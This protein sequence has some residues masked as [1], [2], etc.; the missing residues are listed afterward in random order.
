MATTRIAVLG[1]GL[2]GLAAATRLVAAGHQVTVYEARNRVG[3]RV[4]T[5]T[6]NA[7]GG[8]YPIERGAEFVLNGYSTLN[9][10][11]ESHSLP[12]I[13]TGMSYYIRTPADRPDVTTEDMAALGKSAAARAATLH[14]AASVEQVLD[15]IEVTGSVRDAL[16]ARIE[17]STAVRVDQVTAEGTLDQVASFKPGPS[18][19]VAGGNQR[20]PLAMASALGDRV[21]LGKVVESVF[22]TPTEVR[23]TTGGET[24][25]YDF[26]V[27]A[28]PF[29]IVSDPY[30]LSIDLPEWKTD[31][32]TRVV[33]G[34]AA[35]L[36]IPLAETPNTSAVMSV[37]GR[38]W[39]WTA[40]TSESVVAPVVNC[41]G[42]EIDH[43]LQLKIHE[44]GHEWERQVRQLRQDL[45]FEESGAVLTA[46]PFD[47]LAR[48]SYTAHAPGFTAADAQA[49]A[50]PYG[51][52]FFAGEYIDTDF[53]GLMEGALRS[54]D[55]AAAAIITN[56]SVAA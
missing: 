9:A 23:I 31:A 32:M 54:G 29:A 46:W 51:R 55:R 3:G 52:L 19:R 38:H 6:I 18:W 42:G 45:E 25:S 7:A 53:T 15:L 16:A 8:E 14:E 1:A 34:N 24:E 40:N 39:S 48:G 10:Y 21:R 27:V 28:L 5:E 41:F 47:P 17:M 12:L 36:H 49:L 26:V 4:W 43:L 2:A 35:K 56:A 20:L 37:S 22:Q 11:C 50:A 33:Q 44:G 13:D 30:A